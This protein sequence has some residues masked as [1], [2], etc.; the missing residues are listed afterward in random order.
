MTLRFRITMLIEARSSL[1]TLSNRK[2]GATTTTSSTGTP[3]LNSVSERKF[4]SCL[5]TLDFPYFFGG[6]PMQELVTSPSGCQPEL[7]KEICH[8]AMIQ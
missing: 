1:R 7:R 4:S 6:I 5:L 2:F 3:E 8:H